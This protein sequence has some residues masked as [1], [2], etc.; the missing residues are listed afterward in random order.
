MPEAEP[1][2]VKLEYDTTLETD[3]I[4]KVIA[5]VSREIDRDNETTVSDTQDRK[6]LEAVLAALHIAETLQKPISREDTESSG[7]T[8]ED[9]DVVERL[10]QRAQRL[11]ASDEM[12]GI[13]SP[14][15][16]ASIDV[17]STR[18]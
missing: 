6:D 10:Q 17:P 1:D 4:E 11:G 15:R 2:D 7:R 3:T 16:T 14:R 18:S 13:G 8:Y 9:G 12:I 5:R